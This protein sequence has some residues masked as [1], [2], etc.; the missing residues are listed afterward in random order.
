MKPRPI[1][2]P[3]DPALAE[4]CRELASRAAAID[5][6]GDWPAEQ[7]RLCGEYGVYQW[8][9]DPQWG[10]QAW[11]EEHVLRGYLALAAACLTTTF[12]LTQRKAP[13]GGSKPA[14]TNR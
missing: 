10:G 3:D 6:T 7:F 1:T 2:S 8:F 9:A 14:I 5:E 13:A 11:S 4:L 12:V